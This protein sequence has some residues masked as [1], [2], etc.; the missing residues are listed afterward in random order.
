MIDLH[1]G[2][3][4]YG[5]GEIINGHKAGEIGYDRAKEWYGSETTSNEDGNSSSAVVHGDTAR[6]YI[7]GVPNA[8]VTSITLEYGTQPLDA[9]IDSVRADNWLHVHGTL[10]SAQS[11][12]IKRQIRDAFWGKGRLEAHGA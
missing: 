2:L 8:E 9:V 12:T 6:N 3:G 11:R 7:D 4:P 1:T 5:Y 10:D